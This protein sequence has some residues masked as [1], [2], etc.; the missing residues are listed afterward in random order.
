VLTKNTKLQLF[1]YKNFSFL[2]YKFFVHIFVLDFPTNKNR[3]IL[4]YTIQSF[5]NNAVFNFINQINELTV[6]P[7][8]SQLFS[9]AS[10][11]E[12]EA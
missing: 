7:S 9:G 11:S 8:V 2:K 5:K 12:R 3:F 10:W 1:I 6:V 4:N